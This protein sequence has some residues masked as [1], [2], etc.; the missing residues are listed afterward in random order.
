MQGLFLVLFL[1]FEIFTLQRRK[2]RISYPILLNLM[3][4]FFVLFTRAGQ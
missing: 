4:V 2:R 1:L 3:Q